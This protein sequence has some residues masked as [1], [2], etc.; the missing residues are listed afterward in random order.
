MKIAICFSGQPRFV[1]EG[2]KLFE[3]NLIGF[4]SA[5]I[6]SHTW[7]SSK[8][9][10]HW[11]LTREDSIQEVLNLYKITDYVDEPQKNDIAP[12]G[13]SDEEFVHWSMFYS[14]YKSNEIKKQYESKHNIKYD[15][16]IRTRFDCALLEPLD[17]TKYSSDLVYSPW[18][19]KHGVIMDWLNFSNSNIIDK[20]VEVYNNMAKYKTQKVLM[21]SGEELLSH[22]LNTNNIKYKSCNI[23][24]KL[25]RANTG[26][27]PGTW[28]NVNQL[29]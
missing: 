2:Y 10:N 12:Q 1:E 28:V 19:H 14:V 20:H 7:E 25:I 22:H 24:C 27:N 9:G 3:K 21:T 16:V 17:V 18:I 5:D 8:K 4:E 29:K 26:S 15:F 23:D 11:N 13:L 6:F